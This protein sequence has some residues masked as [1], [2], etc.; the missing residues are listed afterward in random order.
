MSPHPN[1][2]DVLAALRDPA[3]W[4]ERPD[5]VD[6]IETHAAIV[7]LAGERALKIKR[8]IR[9][10]YLDFSTLALRRRICE[11]EVEINAPHAPGLYRGV[12]PIRAR[13]DGRI[14]VDSSAGDIVEWAVDMCRFGQ[15]HL[16][17]SMASEGRLTTDIMKRLADRI[18]A[19]H[20]A[21]PRTP[22]PTDQ[23]PRVASTV[24]G[25]VAT[26]TE[27]T[28]VAAGAP[29][30]ELYAEAFRRSSTPRE[31]RSRSGHMRRCHGDLHLKNLVMWRGEPVPFDALEFDEG[32][33]NIDT[34]YDLAFLLMDLDRRGARHHANT[35]L[36]RYLWRTGDPLD[37]RGLAALPLYLGLR[38]GVRAMVALDRAAVVTEPD[39]MAHVAETLTYAVRRLQSE[40]PLL[41]AIGGLSGTGKTTVA[42]SIAPRIGAA[43][44]ALHLRTDLER[45][46]L[47]GVEETERL[48]DDAYSDRAT[49]ATYERVLQRAELALAAGHSVIVDGVFAAL[50]ERTAIASIA[51][52]TGVPFRGLW[53]VASPPAMKTRVKLREADASDATV[54]VLERQLAH[55]PR[56]DDWNHIDSNGPPDVVAALAAQSIGLPPVR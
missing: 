49:R 21:A 24:L 54:A 52:R 32:L 3:N 11:R 43:P 36:N 23:L 56:V 33:A 39:A 34:L 25:A 28:V 5:R 51:H 9:L 8:A 7:F 46:W 27:P 13:L 29:L 15:V 50:P 30:A 18:V 14:V 17:S 6:V 20:E 37:L 10:P 38:A 45:K 41:V 26:A 16:L 55:P 53:L 2:A 1:Q 4:P 42:G 19:Y 47:A 44:G 31:E 48:P 12:V 22:H 35:L 40:P